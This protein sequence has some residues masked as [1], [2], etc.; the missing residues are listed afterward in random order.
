MTTRSP[1]WINFL[2]V[3]SLA[4]VDP[5][6]LRLEFRAA[7]SPSDLQEGPSLLSRRTSELM[8]REGWSRIYQQ[9]RNTYKG[10]RFM[11]SKAAFF[12]T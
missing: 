2:P 1:H 9:L 11:R 8:H 12:N 6:L 7:S 5:R 4:P 10:D 3:R